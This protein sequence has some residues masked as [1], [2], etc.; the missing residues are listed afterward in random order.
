MYIVGTILIYIYIYIYTIYALYSTQYL[1]GYVYVYRPNEKC[2]I[3]HTEVKFT[4]E[5][6]QN[7]TCYINIGLLKRDFQI[8]TS[9]RLK[10][11][12]AVSTSS[13]SAGRCIAERR[14]PDWLDNSRCRT[15]LL[16]SILNSL[17]Q[18]LNVIEFCSI[19]S[20]L[21]IFPEIKI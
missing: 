20:R 17:L 15:N 5:Y 18:V 2:T 6:E 11:M 19:G 4:P 7:A 10:K 16:K 9:G 21:Q 12:L 3:I 14:F 8:T 13:F 1:Y